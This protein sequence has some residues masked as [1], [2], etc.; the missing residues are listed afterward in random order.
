[1][2]ELLK[3]NKEDHARIHDT[4]TTI[5]VELASQ[6]ANVKGTAGAIAVIISAI[7]S[8]LGWFMGHLLRG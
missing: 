8:F 1:V 2:A 5:Q 7:I 6:R 4:L 3:E